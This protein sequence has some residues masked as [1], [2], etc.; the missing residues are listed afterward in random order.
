[1]MGCGKSKGDTTFAG[2]SRFC[3]LV[4]KLNW[5]VKLNPL[6]VVCAIAALDDKIVIINTIIDEL[7]C[8]ILSPPQHNS[9]TKNFILS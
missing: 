3:G 6:P 8:L 4:M 9:V 2:G 5:G 1:M 7:I